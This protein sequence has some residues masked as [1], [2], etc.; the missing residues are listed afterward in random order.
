MAEDIVVAAPADDLSVPALNTTSSRGRY[1]VD[2]VE[3]DPASSWPRMDTAPAGCR[4]TSA[5]VELN[6]TTA[7][8]GPKTLFVFMACA[9]TY[10][11]GVSEIELSRYT[12]P[13]VLPPL[14]PAKYTEP[15]VPC[16]ESPANTYAFPPKTPVPCVLPPAMNKSAAAVAEF[17]GAILTTPAIPEEAGPDRIK[18][19]PLAAVLDVTPV[20]SETLPVL[21]GSA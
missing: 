6:V 3:L 9:S 1:D 14:P 2:A 4:C 5:A 16:C 19:L 18:T 15:P 20:R 12:A 7:A 17:P 21:L 10:M 13:V 11:T 8:D